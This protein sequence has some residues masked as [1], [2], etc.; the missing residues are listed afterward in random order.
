MTES[1]SDIEALV[2]KCRAEKSREHVAEAVLCYRAG[3]YR[4]TIVNAWIAIVFDLI[5]KIR[6]LAR[7][8]DANAQSLNSQYETYLAQINS[9]SEQGVKKALEFEREILA[10]CRDK[11]QFFDHQQFRDLCRLREDRHQCAHPSFQS[12]GEPYRPS[13]EQARMHLRNA[14]VHVL[15]Q[16][17][18]QGKM[19]IAELIGL[20]DS[21]YFPSD[22]TRA[23]VAFRNSPLANGTDALIRGF[24][25]ALIF[26]YV[27]AANQLHE[28]PQVGYALN[29][30]LQL[31]RAIAEQRLSLQLSKLIRQL[32]DADLSKAVALIGLVPI[33]ISLIDHHAQIR[34]E[35]FLRA[36]PEAEVVRAISVFSA[37]PRYQAVARERILTFTDTTLAEGIECYGLRD[38]ATKERALGL[39]AVVGSWHGANW[40]LAKCIMPLFESLTREDIERIIRMPTESNAD[41]PGATGYYTFISQVQSSQRIPVNDLHQLLRSNRGEYMIPLLPQT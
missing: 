38:A 3:A 40:H 17:P 36:G 14:V 41:L 21:N 11:L 33:S 18:V 12:A 15:S 37:D 32:Q 28:K 22:V 30:I 29:A 10:T 1:L 19:A 7:A 24:A 13:A 23:V 31:H 2:L 27:D 8:G 35:E 26:G 20:V 9:G 25:D 6:D 4:S 16:P 39:L 5:D 34:I